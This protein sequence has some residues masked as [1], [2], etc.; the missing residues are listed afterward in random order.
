MTLGLKNKSA[1]ASLTLGLLGWALYIFQW[2]FD[3]TLGI[4]LAAMTV[5]VSALVSS[6][7]DLIPFVLWLAGIITGHLAIKQIKREGGPGRNQAIWGLVLN[8]LGFL[9]STIFLIVIAILI[10]AGFG[11]GLFNNIIPYFH[12]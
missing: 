3:L 7:L 6:F 8:Y 10:F 5:G 1:I 9:F 11:V 12:K 4:F 2:C